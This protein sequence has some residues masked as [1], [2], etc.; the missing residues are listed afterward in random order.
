MI[1]S[2]NDYRE[3]SNSVVDNVAKLFEVTYTE[4]RDFYLSNR[5]NRDVSPH[6]ITVLGT[7][8]RAPGDDISSEVE[9]ILSLMNKNEP[10]T[11][12]QIKAQARWRSFLNWKNSDGVDDNILISILR[13]INRSSRLQGHMMIHDMGPRLFSKFK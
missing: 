13:G 7:P 11:Q 3:V 6:E 2:E 8:S 4:T 12:K 10:T 5:N 9:R 1:L